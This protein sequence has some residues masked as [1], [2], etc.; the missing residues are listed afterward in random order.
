M[1]AKAK[2]Q[3]RVG[4]F[5]LGRLLGWYLD[6]TLMAQTF[7]PHKLQ[8]RHEKAKAQALRK[9]AQKRRIVV[10]YIVTSLVAVFSVYVTTVFTANFSSLKTSFWLRQTVRT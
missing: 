3:R 4:R 5:R 1:S 2:M 9:R 6:W 10:P 7:D 8:E